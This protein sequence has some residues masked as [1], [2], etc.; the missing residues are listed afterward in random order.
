M[1]EIKA[2][3]KPHKLTVVMLALHQ[4]EGLT[5]VSI[6]DVRGY[7]RGRGEQAQTRM[8]Q[9]MLT[10]VPHL[11]VEIV[12]LDGL[13]DEV[14]AAI[15]RAA[16]TG[17]RGDGKIYVTNVEAAIRISTGETGEAAV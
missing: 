10:Y 1:K 5:G 13:V 16:H 3:I 11:R 17:G 8:I 9:D 14:V 6:S 7:G 4:I 2:Y 15:Q 12:C